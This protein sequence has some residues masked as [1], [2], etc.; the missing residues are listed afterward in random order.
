MF[1]SPA[2]RQMVAAPLKTRTTD[3]SRREVFHGR[4]APF[5]RRLLN[6]CRIVRWVQPATSVICLR[7]NKV[8]TS[9]AATAAH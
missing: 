9:P 6:R 3:G 2:R 4:S 8:G 5:P 1:G 7:L